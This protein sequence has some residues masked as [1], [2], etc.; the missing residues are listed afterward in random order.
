MPHADWCL[1]SNGGVPTSF[2]FLSFPLLPLKARSS[3]VRRPRRR[4]V[5]GGLS[6]LSADRG[7]RR[8]LHH[9]TGRGCRVTA[10]CPRI[11]R[12]LRRGRLTWTSTN[13]TCPQTTIQ[14]HFKKHFSLSISHET[15]PFG[16]SCGRPQY[17]P[18]QYTTPHTPESRL[19]HTPAHRA[20]PPYYVGDTA[21]E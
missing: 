1:Q 16:P 7:Q 4:A 19:S 13:N 2:F 5:A 11:D 18:M 3:A 17:A 8:G 21:G 15:L 20:T 10:A 12:L 6:G 9:A 14:Y